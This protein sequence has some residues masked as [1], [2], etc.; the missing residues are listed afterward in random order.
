[1]YRFYNNRNNYS[2]NW[3]PVSNLSNPSEISAGAWTWQ[4]DPLTGDG[5]IS[6]L[7]FAIPTQATGVCSLVFTD[8]DIYTASVLTLDGS[9]TVQSDNN[10]SG[11]LS[12]TLAAGEYHVV[13]DIS[14]EQGASLTIEPGVTMLFD[15]EYSFDINGYLHAVGTETDSIKFMPSEVDVPWG[16]IDCNDSASDDSEM[17]YCLITGSNSSGIFCDNSSPAITNCTISGNTAGELGGGILCLESSSPSITNCTVSDNT[18]IISGGGIYCY[19]GSNPTSLNNIFWANFAPTGNQVQLAGSGTFTS[20]YSDIQDTLWPG[21]GNI[22]LDPLFYEVD[23]DSSYYLWSNSPCV[24]A[25]DPASP[26]DP[27]STVAD[28]G[29]MWP[30]IPVVIEPPDTLWTRTYGGVDT[31][32]GHCVISTF[33]GGYIVGG[34]TDSFGA[35]FED[36]YLIK[37]EANGDTSWTKTFGGSSDDR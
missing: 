21:T 6:Y 35:G 5:I 4:S 36:V 33:D 17:G 10:L 37:T 1:M 29:A 20:A 24:D 11:P 7:K 13:G 15:G 30:P 22:F 19:N 14:V 32:I 26:L 34:Y 2:T 31:D 25:G 3:N 27:D 28:M 18:A 12:G 8:F 23:E 9:I 16:G